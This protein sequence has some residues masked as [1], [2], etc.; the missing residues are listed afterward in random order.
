[1][2]ILLVAAAMLSEPAVVSHIKVISDKAELRTVADLFDESQRGIVEVHE[3]YVLRAGWIAR[4]PRGR[5]LTER[6]RRVVVYGALGS[7]YSASED[8]NG[9]NTWIDP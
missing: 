5:V 6:A 2:R 1:M 8:Q 4:T 3:P 7:S 9:M